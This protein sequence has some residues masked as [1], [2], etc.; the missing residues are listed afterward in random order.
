[1]NAAASIVQ[2]FRDALPSV[3]GRIAFDAPLARFTWFGVG[4]PADVLFRPQDADDLATFM[5]ALP[6][7]V[8]VWPLGVGSNVIIRDGGVR[9]VVVLLRGGFTEVEAEDDVVVAGAGALAANVARR[10]AD[11][12]LGGLEFLSGV[13]GSVGGAVRMNAGAYGGEVTDVLVSAEVVT[14]AGEVLRL[15]AAELGFAYRH[16]DL[17]VDDIVVRSAFRGVEDDSDVV[18]QRLLDV[19]AKREESQ[20]LRSRTG[21]STFRNPVGGKAWELIDAAGCRG[22]QVGGA[23]VSEKH[24][25]FLIAEDGAT[26]ADIEALGAAVHAAVK[27]SSGIDLHWEIKRVGRALPEG[28]A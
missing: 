4:G 6:D 9:G 18:R 3:K 21:G 7:D 20:P 16:S 23:K 12:G 2:D 19:Q 17:A 10:G 8:P 15:D 24:C 22:M 27:K 28:G 1:M 11:A 13:P 26:A 5:A 25:N 14:R